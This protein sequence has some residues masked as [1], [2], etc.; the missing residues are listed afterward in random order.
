MTEAPKDIPAQGLPGDVRRRIALSWLAVVADRFWPALWPSTGVIGLFLIVALL[1]GF[2]WMPGGLHVLLL[3]GFV[4][5]LAWSLYWPVRGKTIPD[6]SQ[7]LRHLEMSSGLEHRPITGLDDKMGLKPEPGLAQTLW[8]AHR[9]QL[10]DRIRNLQIRWP[11][12]NLAA[13]DPYAVRILVLIVL[14]AAGIAAGSE[15]PARIAAAFDTSRAQ[16]PWSARGDAWL[17][18]PAYTGEEI[19]ALTLGVQ[20]TRVPV[21]AV[22]MGSELI[23]RIHE[24]SGTAEL[25][26]GPINSTVPDPQAIRFQD[27]GS[28]ASE[29]RIKITRDLSVRLSMSGQIAGF[30]K[31]KAVADTPPLVQFRTPMAVMQSQTLRFHYSVKDDYGVA[32]LSAKVSRQ[33]PTDGGDAGFDFELPLPPKPAR[34]GESTVFKDLTAHRWAGQPVVITLVATDGAGQTFLTAP[35]RITLP[36]RAFQQP[37]ARALIE[38]RKELVRDPRSKEKVAAT[39]D[40]LA[41]APEY[42]TPDAAVYLG[43]R[44][45]HYRLTYAHAMDD[46]RPAEDL[47]WSLALKV[48]DG[49]AADAQA[50]LRRIQQQLAKAISDGASDAEIAQ[51]MA[52]F[53]TAMQNYLQAMQAN[54]QSAPQSATQAGARGMNPQDL[55]AMLDKIETL[56]RSGSAEAAQQMLSELQSIMESLKAAQATGS[57]QEQSAQ[58]AMN[59]LKQMMKQ[60][61]DLMDKTFREQTQSASGDLR[62]QQLQ[63]AQALANEQENMA[64]ALSEMMRKMMEAGGNPQPLQNAQSAMSAA[65]QSLKEGA[66][67]DAQGDQSKA[68]DSLRQSGEALM[69]AMQAMASQRG[70]TGAGDGMGVGD[71]QDPFGRTGPSFGPQTGGNVKVPAKMDIQRAREIM[72]ELQRRAGERG[73]PENELDYLDRLLRR[74]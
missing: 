42:F 12:I 63:R 11:D 34:M 57:P 54:A 50:E 48:E 55:K 31:I 69:Q 49:A 17:K 2:Q 4:V 6:R 39:L 29:A 53:R 13:R 47:L 73:R 28:G 62:T 56:A 52:Q 74:F 16:K 71:N 23:V 9:R 32:S 33:T 19:R 22:P 26:T 43:L 21:R 58:S 30:W 60:Q 25:K 37:L 67:G 38:Q 3:I 44:V 68:L 7:A 1:N 15:A 51:L 24:G 66:F 65:A 70:G 18:P 20:E 45:A 36:E 72:E 5:A 64:K 59:A 61:R 46:L 40:A 10:F 35:V 27:V 41:V 14:V 8:S